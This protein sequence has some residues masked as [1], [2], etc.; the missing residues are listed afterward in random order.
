MRTTWTAPG[1]VAGKVGR[2]SRAEASRHV[3][4]TW[5]GASLQIRDLGS[6]GVG[7]HCV[8]LTPDAGKPSEASGNDICELSEHCSTA[9]LAGSDRN[10][11]LQCT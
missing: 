8:P 4:S 11:M 5:M 3:T 6:L 1:I 9:F 2:A 7:T 10:H